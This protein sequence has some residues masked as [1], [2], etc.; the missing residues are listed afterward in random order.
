MRTTDN[1]LYDLGI[2]REEFTA[3]I[4]DIIEDIEETKYNQA[5]AREE[6]IAKQNGFESFSD[7]IKSL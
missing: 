6:E 7:Y 3:M 2:T 1:I 4:E 5:L